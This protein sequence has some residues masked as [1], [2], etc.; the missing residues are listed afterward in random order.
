MHQ[1]AS[2]RWRHGKRNAFEMERGDWWFRT[3]GGEGRGKGAGGRKSGARAHVTRGR[4]AT[5]VF[6]AIPVTVHG[7]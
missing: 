4:N 3:N 1:Q 5:N 6:Q 7:R 2:N